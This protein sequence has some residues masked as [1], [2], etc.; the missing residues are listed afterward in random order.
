MPGGFIRRLLCRDEPGA[1]ALAAWREGLALWDAGA[2][3]EAR[4]KL[5]HAIA[6]APGQAKWHNEL[7]L[8]CLALDDLGAAETAFRLA[9]KF[10]PDL[11]EAECN[12]GI[13]LQQ[14]ADTEAA[15]AS[16]LVHFR[17]AAEFKPAL[18][19]AQYNCGLL[20]C[21]MARVDE[22][23][24][25]FD[26]ALALDPGHAD[27]WRNR[28]YALQDLR[29]FDE[30]QASF[31]RA[32]AVRPD[33]HEVRLSLAFLHLLRGRFRE[34]W[35]N[36]RAREFTPES[37]LRPFPCQDWDG[38][39]LAGRTLLVYGEQGLGDEILFASCVPD[40]VAQ[41][42]HVV[43][44]C[45]PR[46]AKLFAR[47]FPQASVHGGPRGADFSWLSSVAQP[48]CKIAT[49]N[50]PG[51]LRNDWKD[52][53]ARDA[54]LTADSDRVAFWKS[55]LDALG[56][57][58][59]IGIAWRG[60]LPQTR[61]ALRSLKLADL[62]PV[63]RQ[64]GP[65]FVS[66]Q[67]GDTADEIA[68]LQAEH[69]IAVA[70][71]EDAHADYD[72]TAALMTALD[73]VVTVCT[74]IVHLAGALG[75]TAL[76]MTPFVPEWRYLADGEAMPWYRSVHLIRQARRGDWSDVF[77]RVCGCLSPGRKDTAVSAAQTGA[78]GARQ[79]LERRIESFPE[80]AGAHRE[81]A[82]LALESGEFEAAIDAFELALHFA[83]G[84]VDALT[85]LARALRLTGRATEAEGRTREALLHAPALLAPRLELAAV[86][87]AQDRID[88]AIAE[89]RKLLA[90]HGGSPA[91]WCSLGLALHLEAEYEEAVA[92]L[93]RALELDPDFAEAQHNLGLA[94]REL[95]DIEGAIAAFRRALALKP[96]LLA[97]HGALAHALRDLGRIDEA[98]A[99]YDWVLADR[100]Q[101]GDALLNRAYAFL[102][103]GE[104]AR[105]WD[106]YEKRIAAGGF[107]PRPFPLPQWDGGPTGGKRVLVVGEQGLGDE[108][109]FA[110]CIPDLIA[111]EGSCVI[112]CNAR[113]ASLYARSF[114]VP[115]RG[116]GKQDDAGWIQA[117]PDLGWQIQVGSL[118]RL[119]RREPAG[120]V[121]GAPGFLKADPARAA[122]WRARFDTLG[123]G[124][125]IGISWRG[126]GPRTRGR[127]RSMALSELA[128]LCRLP[129]FR[130]VSLQHGDP[131]P[132]LARCRHDNGMVVAAW[133]GTG[134]DLDGL[135]AMIA[136]LDLVVTIDNTVAHLAGALGKPVWIMIPRGAE[137][138]YGC[139]G[140][141][142]PWYPSARLF[143]QEA[144]G[145]PGVIA[146]VAAA[147]LDQRPQ[148]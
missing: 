50:V 31:E 77:A 66:L 42:N 145:W 79:T 121:A 32:L 128:P 30:A 12:L 85:G 109:M 90:S 140:E 68:A 82:R 92:S 65:C 104:Y 21:K 38:G 141:T 130:V 1:A 8:V 67:H 99:E 48:D 116:G 95:G 10:E 54:Y 105:G 24:P 51:F 148:A 97:T 133:P 75:T 9:L 29:R 136:G 44:D 19:S 101:D 47:S 11:A 76:V 62:L 106:E 40:L 94:L 127:L 88:E 111:R 80:D 27:A 81:L 83:P 126:G 115:V 78:P 20:L 53:P 143:R 134:A 37:P 113:L 55:R 86:L 122:D 15:R 70:N 49:G 61:T 71:W 26:R 123:A 74:S 96:G 135:A 89:Y 93:S 69:G 120:F 59:K 52:F 132:E 144:A 102:M 35:Q 146:R 5:E 28:G 34:G 39:P 25:C 142:M 33:Y 13:V 43:L 6:A 138:R 84:D 64:P 119:F 56:P 63:L 131:E 139:G 46:L 73:Q 114:G 2:P 112:E 57:G 60:G 41:A 110:S 3:A 147:L 36:Y 45:E 91:V 22:A 129:G 7:G 23:V 137:W 100:P 108:I 107:A 16:A 118:P 103:R 124:W 125:K 98:L 117:H 14:R 18:L 17:R 72:E 58:P 87:K 4:P